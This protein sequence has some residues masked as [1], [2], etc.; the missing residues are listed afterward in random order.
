MSTAKERLE[1]MGL[2][3]PKAAAPVANYVP[4]VRTG[5]LVVISGQICFGPDGKLDPAHL[6]KLGAEVS[7]ENGIAAAR[8]CAINVLAQVQA[9]V[10]DLDHGVVQCVRLGGFIN[11]V[12]SF[13]GLAGIMNGASDL[14]V[15]VLGDRGRHAR[16]TVGVAELPLDAA[17]EVEA[18]FEVK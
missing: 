3:L 2:T 12:P 5:N 9:A 18:M 7:V 4:F 8:L 11:A 1:A 15:E 6:G 10:G 17:V 14:M 13:S 16:A